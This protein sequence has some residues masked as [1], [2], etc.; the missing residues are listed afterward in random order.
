MAQG[1]VSLVFT[2]ELIAAVISF[3]LQIEVLFKDLITLEPKERVGLVRYGPKSEAFVRGVLRLIAQNPNVIPP[4]F[5]L[6]E[7]QSDL[8]ARD[9]LVPIQDILRRLTT[10][11]DHTVEALGH[12]LMISS[13]E[14]YALLKVSGDKEGLEELRKEV[15]AR[16]AKRR[17]EKPEAENPEE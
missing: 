10:R 9:A 16:F 2:Q 5:D 11:V 3:L 6:T 17:R 4:S 12:D 13:L 15:G 1:K 7:A 8:A 14:A